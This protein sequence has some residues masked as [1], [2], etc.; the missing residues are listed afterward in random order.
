VPE[1][2]NRMEIQKMTVSLVSGSEIKIKSA[3]KKIRLM[4]KKHRARIAV[5]R[6]LKIRRFSNS[7]SL[8]N[9]SSLTIISSIAVTDS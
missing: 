2:K 8:P 5:I 4:L 1:N 7:I 6:A 3:H 9:N